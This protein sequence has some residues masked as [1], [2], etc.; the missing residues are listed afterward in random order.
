MQRAPFVEKRKNS[1]ET[2]ARTP[3][4]RKQ[5]R[6]VCRVSEKILEFDEFESLRALSTRFGARRRDTRETLSAWREPVV[7]YAARNISSRARG[8]VRG[9]FPMVFQRTS[10]PALLGLLLQPLVGRRQP[11]E[12]RDA[13]TQRATRASF[14]LL[15][16]VAP[17]RGGGPRVNSGARAG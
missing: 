15:R 11:S 7:T 12:R 14:F 5:A 6:A 13:P 10:A 4:G 9:R 1:E 8:I 2:T 17:S 16:A 3:R